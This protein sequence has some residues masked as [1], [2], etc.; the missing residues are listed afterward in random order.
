MG[1]AAMPIL[2]LAEGVA[3]ARHSLGRPAPAL[4]AGRTVWTTQDL[5]DLPPPIRFIC[6]A[7]FWARHISNNRT[8]RDSFLTAT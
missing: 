7:M 4:L 3:D 8:I 2:L 6:H 5:A 1:M